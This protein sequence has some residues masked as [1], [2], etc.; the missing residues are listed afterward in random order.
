MLKIFLIELRI[1][2]VSSGIAFDRGPA[3]EIS[4]LGD[5]FDCAA[6]LLYFLDRAL[7]ELV[8]MNP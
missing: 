4:L 2:L 8:S 7:A 5:H 1:G 3:P 6:R